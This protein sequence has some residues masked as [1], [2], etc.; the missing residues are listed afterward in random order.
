MDRDER[1][2]PTIGLYCLDCHHDWNLSPRSNHTIEPSLRDN[3][4]R[5]EDVWRVIH[6]GQSAPN[7]A[8]FH[9]SPNP[10]RH[11][12]GAAVPRAVWA[13][14]K[15]NR[16]SP[17][18][19]FDVLRRRAHAVWTNAVGDWRMRRVSKLELRFDTNCRHVS[20]S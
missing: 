3:D 18:H 11:L 9:S 15:A 13:G 10:S 14:A 2:R 12:V 6:P 7:A 1:V 8:N 4:T 20:L 19:Y 16:T 5:S 17:F